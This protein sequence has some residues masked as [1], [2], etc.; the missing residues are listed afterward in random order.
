M[1]GGMG[2]EMPFSSMED[3]GKNK[4]KL[5]GLH[6][7][8]GYPPHPVDMP[9]NVDRKIPQEE[10]VFHDYESDLDRKKSA[11]DIAYGIED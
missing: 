8:D 5:P 4:P 6:A 10:G 7:H 11:E 2:G 1:G 9:H 3:G